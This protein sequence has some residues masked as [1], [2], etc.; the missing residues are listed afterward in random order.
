M[1][2]LL[3]P[4]F[5]SRTR[6]RS[7]KDDTKSLNPLTPIRTLVEAGRDY[8]KPS[9]T[10]ALSGSG[11][12]ALGKRRRRSSDEN[13]SRSKSRSSLDS[14]LSRSDSS[15]I[16]SSPAHSGFPIS[17]SPPSSPST[18]AQ[19]S[20]SP[21]IL[22]SPLLATSHNTSIPPLPPPP[23]PT[24]ARRRSRVALQNLD[25]QYNAVVITAL[26]DIPFCCHEDLLTM[27]RAQLVAV[28]QSLNVKLPAA[29]QIDVTDIRTDFFIRKS[30][31]V[32]V[33]ISKPIVPSETIIAVPEPPG[34]PRAVKSR[35]MHSMAIVED[36]NTSRLERVGEGR[37]AVNDGDIDMNTW[38]PS[39]PGILSS[40]LA[41]RAVIRSTKVARAFELGTLATTGT[42]KLA[43][44]EEEDESMASASNEDPEGY[45]D[46]RVKK[47]RKFSDSEI[48][49]RGR[50]FRRW[51]G[52]LVKRATARPSSF[53]SPMDVD[54]DVATVQ[55]PSQIQSY[56]L[57]PISSLKPLSRPTTSSSL[58]SSHAYISSSNLTPTRHSSFSP[59][60]LSEQ[61]RGSKKRS[62][63]VYVKSQL[64]DA[65]KKMAIA[66]DATSPNRS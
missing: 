22:S 28:A 52:S 26:E 17:S 30:I 32:L 57:R 6:T 50:G 5:S 8:L 2:Q 49:A 9:P 47:R 43:R 3:S 14:N 31:E 11:A 40:P 60:G 54:A 58:H 37:N 35:K 63:S 66:S 55:L 18:A 4:T 29:M 38:P 41:K 34:A 25:N 36:R 65:L 27:S 42:P 44:L 16:C 13:D 64:P 12:L 46:K 56:R 10:L 39:S 23:T 62:R 45:G 24:P 21:S 61:S 20:S 48:R 19:P 53:S 15:V 51:S 7:P 1:F 59:G 33:G